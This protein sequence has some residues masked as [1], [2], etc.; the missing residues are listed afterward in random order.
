MRAAAMAL[1]DQIVRWTVPEIERMASALRA[2]QRIIG[3]VER[4]LRVA[5]ERVVVKVEVWRLPGE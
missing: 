5:G 4:T 1:G 3:A 2:E